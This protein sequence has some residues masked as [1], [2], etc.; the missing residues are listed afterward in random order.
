MGRTD[1]SATELA[2]EPE[3][4]SKVGMRL[5]QPVRKDNFGLKDVLHQGAFELIH[6]QSP[7]LASSQLLSCLSQGV[8]VPAK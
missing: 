4:P 1:Q 2:L 5:C 7:V 6:C 3:S 8:E